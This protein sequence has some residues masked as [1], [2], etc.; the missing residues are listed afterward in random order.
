[1]RPEVTFQKK[2]LYQLRPG[3]FRVRVVVASCGHFSGITFAYQALEG[4]SI[5]CALRG[6]FSE[7]VLYHLRP[8]LFRVTVVV[9]FRGHFSGRSSCHSGLPQDPFTKKSC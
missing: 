3:L 6:H 8:G 4:Q 5:C 9:A 2:V 1:M 7:K